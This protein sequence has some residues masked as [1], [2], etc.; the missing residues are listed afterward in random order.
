MISS[1]VCG[2]SLIVHTFMQLHP[3]SL[4]IQN[5]YVVFEE[6][7]LVVIATL[8]SLLKHLQHIFICTLDSVAL[9][10]HVFPEKPVIL[11]REM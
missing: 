3:S 11:A 1:Q 7:D 6:G 4:S 9:Y 8:K 10:F 2:N 5:I